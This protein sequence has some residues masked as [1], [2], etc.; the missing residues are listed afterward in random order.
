[1]TY[2][3]ALMCIFFTL[4]LTTYSQLEVKRQV[5]LAGSLPQ[6]M[7]KII[8]FYLKL[9]FTPRMMFAF[10]CVFIAGLSWMAALT[11]L[12]LNYAYPFMSLTFPVVI[13]LSAIIF[14][15]N[16]HWWQYAGV[17]L[18]LQGLVLIQWR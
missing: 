7:D 1:M 4:L 13:I 8:F 16:L 12:P 11:K 5:I 9:L 15:E 6:G 3:K 14:K 17:F 18:L 2:S 10:F